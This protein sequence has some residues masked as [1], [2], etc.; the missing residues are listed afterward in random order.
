MKAR[1]VFNTLPE[2]WD[3]D[4]MSEWSPEREGFADRHP[5]DEISVVLGGELH[6]RVGDTEVVGGPG[7]TIRVPAGQTGYHW[8]PKYARMLGIY[9]PNPKVKTLRNWSTGKSMTELAPAVRGSFGSHRNI[10]HGACM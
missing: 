9:G 2:G 3:T 8:A 1:W 4:A 6:I 10:C 7:D 5:H